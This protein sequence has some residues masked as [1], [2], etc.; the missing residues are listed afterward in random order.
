MVHESVSASNAAANYFMYNPW[1]RRFF[2]GDDDLKR[3]TL[4]LDDPSVTSAVRVSRGDR[5]AVTYRTHASA[6]SFGTRLETYPFAAASGGTVTGAQRVPEAQNQ[7]NSSSALCA[8]SHDMSESCSFKT[9]VNEDVCDI[10]PAGKGVG[11]SLCA[12]IDG[13]CRKSAYCRKSVSL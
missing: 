8:Q 12:P 11:T 10:L 3:Y 2:G 13:P 9:I 7:N 1:K 5:P 6:H 4:H